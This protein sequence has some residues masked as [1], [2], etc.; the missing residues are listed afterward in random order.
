MKVQGDRMIALIDG[1]SVIDTTDPDSTFTDGGI[2]LVVEEG[3]IG[4]DHVAVQP[5]S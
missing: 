3:R 5:F 2:A 4:C 1:E